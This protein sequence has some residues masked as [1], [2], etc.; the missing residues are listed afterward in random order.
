VKNSYS[1]IIPFLDLV[2]PHEELKTELCDVF[3]QALESGG[4]VGG[5]EVNA[6]EAEFAQYCGARY[7]VGVGSGTDALTF[8][9]VAAGVKAGDVVVTV[10]NTFIATVEAIFQAGGQPDFVDID[11]QTYNMD[12]G[13]L[14][15][16][17]EQE[18]SSDQ[19]NGGVINR[20]LRKRVTAI[21]P[22]H[23]YG[24]PANM[25]SILRL[26]EKYQL[27]VIED[28]C[29]A[30]GAAYYS[31]RDLRWNRAGSMGKAA[32]F[33][34]YPGKNLGACGEG[35][36]VITNDEGFAR[37]VQMLR[38]HGQSRKYYHEVEGYNGRLDAIQ[39]GI[40][41]VKLKHLQPWNER[42]R[43]AAGRYQELFRG[44]DEEVTLPYEPWWAQGV[45]HLYVVRVRDRD[46]LQNRLTC[47][48]I[49]T[50]IH[51]PV[52]LHLQAACRKL[53]YKQG[54]FPV[55]ERVSV[56]LLSLPM[57][58]QITEEQQ[59]RV[60]QAILDFTRETVVGVEAGKQKYVST[61]G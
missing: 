40:L 25:D 35:G 48:Q 7:C 41:R 17:L 24:Q 54:A 9:L 38:D 15:E 22:V 5:P 47:E 44:A 32:A 50:G 55:A 45:Y 30:H 58:P 20:R 14:Q 59:F 2:A 12:V 29:Q 8:A 33:S 57:F 51:Y 43:E 34:F 10:P 31:A 28:A 1:R 61:A 18:C 42:R 53:G 4:F 13:R 21:M 36:A 16:Y 52:P 27:V 56:E 46:T 19:E 6:F 49:G 23:L 39:A 60:V 37:L 3:R 26:A 11:E